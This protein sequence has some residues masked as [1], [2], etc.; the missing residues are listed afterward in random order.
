MTPIFCQLC[1]KVSTSSHD[2]EKSEPLRNP[3]FPEMKISILCPLGTQS[4]A[5]P[6][7]PVASQSDHF[8][9]QNRLAFA[10]VGSNGRRIETGLIAK[11]WVR[12]WRE[13]LW[14]CFA[15]CNLRTRRGLAWQNRTEGSNPSL[16]ATQSGL[17]RNP[18]LISRRIC[19]L[20]PFSA[21]FA[22]QTGPRRT[23]YRGSPLP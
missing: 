18:T 1:K 7:K 5:N 8:L 9:P 13:I 11:F 22:R 10:V 2:L 12:F 23:D 4:P 17:Q 15:L 19:E 21:I 6:I 14:Q 20:C 16:S 3:L